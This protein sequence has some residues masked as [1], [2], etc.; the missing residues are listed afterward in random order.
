MHA[1]DPEDALFMRNMDGETLCG[2]SS[3]NIRGQEFYS[4]STCQGVLIL[5]KKCDLSS[6]RW[7]NI[8]V[9][10]ITRLPMSVLKY[11]FEILFKDRITVEDGK[12]HLSS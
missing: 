3:A 7:L 5:Q 9:N 4:Y 11:Y 10:F 12:S 6:S 8:L 2:I 1:V